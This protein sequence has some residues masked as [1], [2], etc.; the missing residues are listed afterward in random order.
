M[1]G[2]VRTPQ[3]R[4]CPPRQAPAPRCSPPGLCA[5][6]RLPVHTAAVPSRSTHPFLP[7]RFFLSHV[8][9]PVSLHL[10]HSSF[11]LLPSISVTF[12]CDLHP[13][14]VP[15]ALYSSSQRPLCG[16]VLV[17]RGG[18]WRS[19]ARCVGQRGR[20]GWHAALCRP[21]PSPPRALQGPP[22]CLAGSVHSL[23][24]A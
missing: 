18:N 2:P 1:Q 4:L 22:L 15:A 16:C 8:E 10:V 21:L 23:G 6:A 24:D 9:P 19:F 12:D 11:S 3:A 17:T 5:R 7:A 20:A 13:F 14:G